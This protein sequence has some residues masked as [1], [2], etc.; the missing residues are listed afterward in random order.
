MAEVFLRRL[1]R[2]QAEQQREALADMYAQ[3]YEGVPGEEFHD[4]QGFLRRFEEHV[5]RPG[6][7]MAVAGA[8][9]LAGCA[10]GYR[11]DRAGTW[12]E[13]LSGELSPEMEE[14]TA[15]GQVFFLAE[16]MVVPAHRRRRVATRLLAHLLTRS[17]TPL[18]V[19]LIAPANAPAA[20]AYRAWAWTRLGELNGGTG[21]PVL[22]AW[23]QRQGG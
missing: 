10:Y 20:E 19:T 15:S 21:A 3:A 13:G 16:L 22:E 6:F 4:R 14:L 5:Q 1:T 9:T 8:G 17:G 7:E 12:W 23:S 18:A 11:A 2:W